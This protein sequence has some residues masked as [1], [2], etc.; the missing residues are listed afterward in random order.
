MEPEETLKSVYYISQPAV[1]YIGN[2]T[3]KLK[4]ETKNG[5]FGG[6][7]YYPLLHN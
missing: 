6:P 2:S 4:A 7:L 5:S 1:G 3:E